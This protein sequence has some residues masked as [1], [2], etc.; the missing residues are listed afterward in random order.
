MSIT[1]LEQA[2]EK[3]TYVVNVAFYDEDSVAMTPDTATWT[4]VNDSNAVVNSR[5]GVSLT[6]ASSIDI[7]L[8]GDNL[9]ISDDDTDNGN[10]R[11]IIEATYSGDLGSGLP[12]RTEA[13]FNVHNISH[14]T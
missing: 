7:V 10:R 1:L 2:N 6:P 5:D 11:I 14:V 3:S 9:A 8:S 12:L 4:L 13:Q